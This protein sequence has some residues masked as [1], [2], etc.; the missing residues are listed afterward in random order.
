MGTA[1]RRDVI[2]DFNHSEGDKI[3]LSGLITGTFISKETSAFD[4]INQIHWSFYGSIGTYYAVVQG[5]VSGDFAPEFE[6]KL[7]GVTAL[8]DTDFN[9]DLLQQA[10]T[11]MLAQANQSGQSVM[12]LLR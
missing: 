8:T 5:N 10:G 1:T 3:D 4:A 12:T 2:T 6:I 9:F 11:A 7:T